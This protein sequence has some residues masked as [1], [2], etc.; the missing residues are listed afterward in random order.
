[1]GIRQQELDARTCEVEVNIKE[2]RASSFEELHRLFRAYRSHHGLG[3][4]FRGHADASWSIL[5]R[6]GR[7]GFSNGLDFG[8]F[9]VWREQA[10]AHGPLPENEW[11]CLAVAQHHGLATRLLDWTLNPLVAAFFAVTELPCRD[12]AV[13]CHF[14][15]TGFVDP[16]IAPIKSL[17]VVAAYLPRAVNE[18]IS[19]QAGVFTVHPDP[20]VEL[21]IEECEEP[22]AG[23]NVVRI[24]IPAE[25]KAPLEQVLGDYGVRFDTLF[26]GLDGLS[27]QV[28][29]ETANLVAR[30]EV[31]AP[32]SEGK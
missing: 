3:W 28:N 27:R 7:A 24:V 21:A 11:E 14:P 5:A 23:P 2:Y 20:S 18:R 17:K 13:I 32:S 25:S 30:G 10:L 1:M 16:T 15:S 9:N 4:F 31:R 19:R 8:R 6:A 26:P 12:G 22:L 29:R